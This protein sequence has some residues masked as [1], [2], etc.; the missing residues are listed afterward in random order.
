[1]QIREMK[2]LQPDSK[3]IT[4]TR[5]TPVFNLLKSEQYQQVA[6]LLDEDAT[7]NCSFWGTN[8]NSFTP[9]E[10]GEITTWLADNK[11]DFATL[12]F[13]SPL[14]RVL[15]RGTFKDHHSPILAALQDHPKFSEILRHYEFPAEQIGA[16]LLQQIPAQKEK[17][18]QILKYVSGPHY[19]KATQDNTKQSFIQYRDAKTSDTSLHLACADEKPD[20]TLIHALLERGA[21]LTDLNKNNISPLDLLIAA[22]TNLDVFFATHSGVLSPEHTLRILLAL[23]Q[24][25][26]FTV[27][28]NLLLKIE[29]DSTHLGDLV[30]ADAKTGDTLIHYAMDQENDFDYLKYILNRVNYKLLNHQNNRLNTALM[31][32]I[33]NHRDKAIQLLFDT[34]LT[35]TSYHNPYDSPDID[36]VQLNQAVECASIGIQPFTDYRSFQGYDLSSDHLGKALLL[37]SKHNKIEF[38]NELLRQRKDSK[39]QYMDKDTHNLAGHYAALSQHPLK[40]KLLVALCSRGAT[41]QERNLQGETAFSILARQQEYGILEN[42]LLTFSKQFSLNNLQ[43]IALSCLSGKK[44]LSLL[45]GFFLTIQQHPSTDLALKQKS[46]VELLFT[47]IDQAKSE[48]E[49]KTIVVILK[50]NEQKMPYFYLRPSFFSST[51]NNSTEVMKEAYEKM[52]QL[53]EPT[54]IIS[55]NPTNLK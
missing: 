6:E 28:K 47:L 22:K 49:I 38:A 50:T 15:S 18:M 8:D 7:L 37:L 46:T 29:A 52:K 14:G 17:A 25:K 33:E 43:Q 4:N 51:P 21:L 54:A 41:L 23:S 3:E 40:E 35:K 27:A 36:P 48:D 13:K 11:I 5:L 53:S 24:K 44:D 30:Q 26:L 31:V 9:K 34:C 1:M 45:P 20:N 2:P 12:F 10:I 19:D 32:A 55:L 39:V 16:F 42:L